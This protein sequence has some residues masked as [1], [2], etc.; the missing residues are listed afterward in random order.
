[1]DAETAP[2]RDDAFPQ[3]QR[4]IIAQYTAHAF[5]KLNLCFFVVFLICDRVLSFEGDLGFISVLPNS[6]GVFHA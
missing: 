6:V 4:R 1:M 5:Q 2:A 3:Q